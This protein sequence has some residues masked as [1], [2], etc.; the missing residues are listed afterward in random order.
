MEVPMFDSQIKVT[1]AA[2]MTRSAYFTLAEPSIEPVFAKDIIDGHS[3]YVGKLGKEEQIAMRL[4][5]IKQTLPHAHRLLVE[6]SASI[7]SVEAQNVRYLIGPGYAVPIYKKV[8]HAIHVCAKASDDEAYFGIIEIS[9]RLVTIAQ[10]PWLWGFTNW[11]WKF[12]E[13]PL[14]SAVRDYFQLMTGVEELQR[15]A[16]DWVR[17]H[18]NLA[19]AAQRKRA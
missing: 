9:K 6:E 1:V 3:Q 10:L 12:S 16:V 5:M 11:Q 14:Q 15:T 18:D 7:L 17:S 13:R 8:A 2:Y 4:A 19:T